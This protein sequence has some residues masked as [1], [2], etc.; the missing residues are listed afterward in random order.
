MVPGT[1]LILLGAFVYDWL[2]A[3]P[4]HALGWGNLLGLTAVVFVSQIVELFAAL[5]GA[6]QFGASKYGVWGA[7]I[8]LFLGLFFSL[9]GLILGPI[10]GVFLGELFS[11]KDHREALRAAWG[12][13]VGNAAGVASRLVAGSIML[14]WIFVAVYR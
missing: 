8:G 12:T 5:L 4:G 2:V 11:G 6:K 13:L 9:P 7:F 10:V 14:I 1:P 3:Q